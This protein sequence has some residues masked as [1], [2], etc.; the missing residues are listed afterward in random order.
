MASIHHS[1]QAAF[2][3]EISAGPSIAGN[4]SRMFDW[5]R[6]W[7]RCR[8]RF[9]GGVTVAPLWKGTCLVEVHYEDKAAGE[10][11]GEKY[12][13]ASYTSTLTFDN[14]TDPKTDRPAP[15]KPNPAS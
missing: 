6:R 1:C 15:A 4:L 7:E 10:I 8:G 3:C 13:K 12:D 11:N 2:C 14:T 9:K 5:L